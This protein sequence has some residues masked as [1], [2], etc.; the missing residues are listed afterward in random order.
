MAGPKLTCRFWPQK[1]RPR[2][3]FG[4]H[5]SNRRCWPRSRLSLS[6]HDPPNRV[7]TSKI[8]PTDNIAG[9]KE[10]VSSKSEPRAP[11]LG[12][13]SGRPDFGPEMGNPRTRHPG[14]TRGPK[15]ARSQAALLSSGQRARRPPGV[16]LISCQGQVT[17]GG[18]SACFECV[19]AMA[20]PILLRISPQRAGFGLQGSD[21]ALPPRPKRYHF[22]PC[23]YTDAWAVDS[24][25]LRTC[26][27]HPRAAPQLGHLKTPNDFWL[28]LSS[29]PAFRGKKQKQKRA[30]AEIALA[31]CQTNP[32]EICPTRGKC[33]RGRSTLA[34]S[35]PMLAEIETGWVEV[36]TR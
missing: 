15:R 2:L 5:T 36:A 14:G 13:D 17:G 33:G 1:G 26:P 23:H 7:G 28:N 24:R 30:T 19:A 9:E 12:Q 11:M 22:G 32:A 3:G 10:E 21:S 18:A 20:A 31:L 25:R 8:G 6:R 4:R 16:Q 35:G 29:M 27:Y 34:D